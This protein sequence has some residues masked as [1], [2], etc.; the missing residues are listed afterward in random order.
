VNRNPSSTF[1]SGGRQTGGG[2]SGGC[3]LTVFFISSLP[4]SPKFFHR[5]FLPFAH[6][7]GLFFLMSLNFYEQYFPS[8]LAPSF[9]SRL[10]NFL[11]SANTSKPLRSSL[12]VRDE[13]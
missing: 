8:S 13:M 2:V 4:M 1:P 11:R 5:F 9:F 12:A 7:P 10:F 3:S 6:L